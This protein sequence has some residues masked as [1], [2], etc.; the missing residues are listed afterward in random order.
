MEP[1][2]LYYREPTKDTSRESSQNLLLCAASLH[3]GEDA[4][5]FSIHRAEGGK[6]YFKSHPH[7]HFSV[8]HS[9]T[10]WACLFAECPIGLDVQEKKKGV[11]FTRLAHRWFHLSEAS[12]VSCEEDFYKIWC[13]KEAFVKALGIGIEGRFK[14]FD[15]TCSPCCLDDTSLQLTSFSLPDGLAERYE[16]A[17]AYSHNFTLSYIRIA[18]Q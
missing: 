6:P 11:T 15:T 8:S 17:V 2:T 10:L 7:L 18:D 16:A 13:R 9:G 4:S 3:T 14:S 5:A 12:K 1:L